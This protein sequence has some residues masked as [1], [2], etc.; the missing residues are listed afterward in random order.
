M[1]TLSVTLA[2]ILLAVSA[3]HV[4]W[5]AGGKAGLTAAI[6]HTGNEPAFTPGRI[7]TLLVAFAL[8]GIATLLLSLGYFRENL[9]EPLLTAARYAAYLASAVLVLRVIGDFKFIGAF[10]KIR[11]S[12]FATLDT[13]I[14]NPLCLLLAIVFFKLAQHTGA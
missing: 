6:P 8:L 11:N 14:Y 5:A 9:P 12:R 1:T 7:V 3:I 10:K 2:G 4:Y 13:Y